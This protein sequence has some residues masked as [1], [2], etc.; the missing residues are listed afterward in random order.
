M[1]PGDPL[2][3]KTRLGPLVSQ[4]QL[5]RVLGYIEKGRERGRELVSAATAPRYERAE[6]GYFLQPTIFDGV[7]PEMTIAREEIFGPVLAV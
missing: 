5:D 7:A 1:Q 3:P 2:D 4:E 6:R